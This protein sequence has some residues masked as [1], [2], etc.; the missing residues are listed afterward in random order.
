MRSIRMAFPLTGVTANHNPLCSDLL[1]FIR[2]N[3]W[4]HAASVVNE[5]ALLG[6]RASAAAGYTKP[7]VILLQTR[8]STRSISLKQMRWPRDTRELSFHSLRPPSFLRHGLCFSQMM[9][10]P[11]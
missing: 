3:H 7:P 5:P 4:T 1:E 2:R 6:A 10:F 8:K 9:P 11:M